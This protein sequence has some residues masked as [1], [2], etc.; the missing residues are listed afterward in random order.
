MN[1][2]G[3]QALNNNILPH[4]NA[5]LPVP[6][7]GVLP[8]ADFSLLSSALAAQNS[9]LSRHGGHIVVYNNL[10][11]L[12][13]N[14]LNNL[15]ILQIYRRQLSAL[16]NHFTR[17]NDDSSFSIRQI[18]NRDFFATGRE[19]AERF[20]DNV[21]FKK[22]FDV[23][24]DIFKDG[25]TE[26]IQYL[27]IKIMSYFYAACESS[28]IFGDINNNQFRYMVEMICNPNKV[29]CINNLQ[30]L[31]SHFFSGRYIKSLQSNYWSAD[32]RSICDYVVSAIQESF[33]LQRA[34]SKF[35]KLL[36]RYSIFSNLKIDG[37]EKPTY[38][39]SAGTYCQL[40]EKISD[41]RIATIK[42]PTGKSRIINLFSYL[43]VI[44]FFRKCFNLSVSIPPLR[45][46]F[47]PIT[48]LLLIAK[49]ISPI[50]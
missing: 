21:Q 18:F 1:F 8:N 13:A 24:D 25:V 19:I 43:F 38:A 39:R 40:L 34:E 41:Y 32:F 2:I 20:Y 42:L 46:N 4:R 29:T 45:Y 22:L 3:I 28:L 17:P 37:N 47:Q 31:F 44:C 5:L 33:N 15:S 11:S 23:D 27:E 26:F 7:R 16:D 36:P 48:P 35:L 9:I 49:I 30:Q 6:I 10:Q 12:R 50:S 14:Y